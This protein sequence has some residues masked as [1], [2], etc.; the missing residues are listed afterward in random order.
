[1]ED[2]GGLEDDV[3][4]EVKLLGKAA[5]SLFILTSSFGAWTSSGT[6]GTRTRVHLVLSDRLYGSL[7]DPA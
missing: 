3:K 5:A 4:A 2:D 7:S 1:M 6:F